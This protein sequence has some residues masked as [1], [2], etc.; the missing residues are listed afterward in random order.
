MI[1]SIFNDVIG[2][3]MRG[4]S[5]SHCAA[6]L[7]I[8]RIARDLMGQQIE[9]VLVQFDHSGSLPATHQTQGSD[10]GLFGGLLGWEAD[11]E[12]L[13]E[14]AKYLSGAN[15][16]LRF[17]YGDYGDAHPNTY[18]L[19]LSNGQESHQLIAISTGG[20]MIEVIQID[21]VS[22]S[23]FGDYYETIAW[24]PAG[25]LGETVDETS[26]RDSLA[27]DSVLIQ[28]HES[29][30]LIQVRSQEPLSDPSIKSIIGTV[31]RVRHLSPVLPVQSQPDTD[32]PF[33]SC[34]QMMQSAE[35]SDKLLW[36]LAVD[37]ETARSGMSSDA[38]VAKMVDLVQLI[39]RSIQQGLAGTQYEDRVLGFQSGGFQKMMDTGQLLDGGM[40]NRIVLYTTALMEVKS[41]MGVIIAAPTA[42]AC[43]ALPA[44]CIAA[45]EVLGKSDEEIARAMLAAGLI[46][47]FITTPWSFA[48]EVG[49]CQ[50]EGGSASAMSAAA[51]V[52]FSNGNRQQAVGAASMA[53]Q[54]MLGLIC[55]PVANRVEVPCLGKNVMAASNALSCANMSLSGFDCVIPFDETVEA[56]KQV[57]LRMPREHRCTALGGLSTTPT[58]LAIEKRMSGCGSGCGCG[59]VVTPELKM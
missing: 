45:G 16:D 38:V 21:G 17:E 8:G 58:S 11:D 51:L 41:S 33:R 10:M 12:R 30:D 6:A 15:I 19:H 22:V 7:R 52:T 1:V 26:V 40:L 2:P 35:G 25:S 39:R 57:A 13:P 43:A 53:M 29:I 28:R 55:D 23:L 37:Y 59:P 27:A 46:G 24:A 36:Q 54:N 5:S 4:P 49:G 48:A 34:T 50:A 42:G 31:S 9:S 3:V 47:V 32:V 14:S 18:R 56:A 20:G 44:T